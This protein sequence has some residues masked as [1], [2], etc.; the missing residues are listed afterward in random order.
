MEALQKFKII[1]PYLEWNISLSEISKQKNIPLR[2]MQR[3]VKRYTEQGLAG[4]EHKSRSDKNIYRAVT[5]EQVRI[6]QALALEKPRLSITT[7]YRKITDLAKQQNQTFPKYDVIYRI[8][9]KMDAGLITLAHEGSTAYR[10]KFEII[11]RRETSSVNEIWQADHTPLDIFLLN[12]KGEAQKPWLTIIEDDCS[13]A[14]SGF[15]LTFEHPSA[16]NTALALRQA[17]WKKK[18]PRWQVCGI[19]QILYTDNG[20]DFISD[21]IEKVCISLKIRMINTIPGRPQGK[22]RVERFFLTLL[23]KLLERLP[24]YAPR[25]YSKTKPKL[26]L[27][28]FSPKLE[29]FII[30]EYHQTKH[31]VTKQLPIDHWIGD[32]FLPQL[33]ESLEQL[34]LLLL[35][36]PKTRKVRRDGIYFKQFRYMSSTLAAFVGEQVTIRYDPRDLA[37]IRVYFEGKFVCPAICQDIADQVISLKEIKKARQKRKRGL[38]KE[39]NSS[40]ELLRGNTPKKTPEPIKKSTSTKAKKQTIKL[41]KNE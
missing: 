10:D 12:E 27:A 34:D 24:G 16:V 8:L 13:R 2:T 21:H 38:R 4:L 1:Q 41:Y 3:W 36:I 11:Y 31:S 28:E 14:I 22:G 23:T 19:P 25:G 40:K 20:S 26:T 15:Y 9:N 37:E 7:I 39:I 33:P 18:N 32:G 35:T 29:G 17:I 30:N 5:K 6:I